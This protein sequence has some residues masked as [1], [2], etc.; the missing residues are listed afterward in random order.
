VLEG[1]DLGAGLAVGVGAEVGTADGLGVTVADGLGPAGEAAGADPDGVTDAATDG[2]GRCCAGTCRG[3]VVVDVTTWGALAGAVDGVTGVPG[4]STNWTPRP[5]ETAKKAAIAEAASALDTPSAATTRRGSRSCAHT[6]SRIRGARYPPAAAPWGFAGIRRPKSIVLVPKSI[7]GDSKP[8][9]ALA[10]SKPIAV[11]ARSKPVGAL[12]PSK[13]IWAL[14]P[15]KPTVRRPA[16]GP[17]SVSTLDST[18]V[19]TL[20]STSAVDRWSRS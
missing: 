8:I 19:S 20:D 17:A 7:V 14:D 2:D 16:P 3:R 4:A 18:S 5:P 12:A 15:P 11:L 10:P 6:P 13:P 1:V 9:G